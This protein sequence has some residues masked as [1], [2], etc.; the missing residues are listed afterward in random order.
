MR[1]GRKRYYIVNGLSHS[2]SHSHKKHNLS[3]SS[4]LTSIFKNVFSISAVRAHTDSTR[5][6]VSTEVED[7]CHLSASGTIFLN[8]VSHLSVMLEVLPI[9]KKPFS[10]VTVQ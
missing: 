4:C 8:E 2:M 7:K 6:Y 3:R 10:T 1:D 9:L 5:L